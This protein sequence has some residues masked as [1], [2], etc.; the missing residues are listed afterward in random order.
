MSNLLL[1]HGQLLQVDALSLASALLKPVSED[2][3]EVGQVQVTLHHR[4]EEEASCEVAE[5]H[6]VADRLH[7]VPRQVVEGTR[8]YQSELGENN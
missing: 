6:Q 5:R 1:L 8:E 4:V 7:D 3:V 2:L